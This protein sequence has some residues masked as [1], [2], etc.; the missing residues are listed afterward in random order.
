MELQGLFDLGV[1]HITENHKGLWTTELVIEGNFE[2]EKI[3]L[4]LYQNIPAMWQL[5]G[6]TEVVVETSYGMPYIARFTRG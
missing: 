1:S 4:W 3:G 6:T 2:N 5:Q